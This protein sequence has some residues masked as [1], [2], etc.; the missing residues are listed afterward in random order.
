MTEMWE[1]SYENGLEYF[2]RVAEAFWILL[3]R[4][5]PHELKFSV[6]VIF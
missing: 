5:Q 4:I 1:M 6:N 3:W 2:T